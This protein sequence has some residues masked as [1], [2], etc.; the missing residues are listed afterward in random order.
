MHDWIGAH[1]KMNE[2]TTQKKD[3]E[4]EE[5]KDMAQKRKK[6]DSWFPISGNIEIKFPRSS[7]TFTMKELDKAFEDLYKK[8][9]RTR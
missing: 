7:P 1:E 9:K 4:I 8:K 5:E 6:E 3:S 2:S